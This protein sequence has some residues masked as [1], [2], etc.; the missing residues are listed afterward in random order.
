[1]S[2]MERHGGDYTSTQAPGTFLESFDHSRPQG[3]FPGIRQPISGSTYF[4]SPHLSCPSNLIFFD[5]EIVPTGLAY[6]S[7]LTHSGAN[8][9]TCGW[10]QMNLQPTTNGYPNS[11][12]NRHCP[13][14]SLRTTPGNRRRQKLNCCNQCGK[15]GFTGSELRKH[16]KAHA[17][18][19]K[20]DFQGCPRKVGFSSR[21]DLDRHKWT[22]HKVWSVDGAVFLCPFGTCR[23][24]RKPWPRADNFRAHLGRVHG[25][26]YS[27]SNDLAEYVHRLP[28]SQD[29]EDVTGSVLVYV[30]DQSQYSDGAPLSEINNPSVLHGEESRHQVSLSPETHEALPQT[31]ALMFFDRITPNLAPVQE[32]DGIYPPQTC[33]NTAASDNQT[34]GLLSVSPSNLQSSNPIRQELPGS[35]HGS[36]GSESRGGTLSMPREQVSQDNQLHT[37]ASGSPGS[38][39][40]EPHQS[41]IEVAD[42]DDTVADTIVSGGQ[43]TESSLSSTHEEMVQLLDRIPKHMIQAYLE[44]DGSLGP[45]NGVSERDAFADK[46]QNLPHKCPECDKSFARKC[47]LTKHLMR[48]SRPYGCTFPGCSKGYGS[49]NDWMRHESTMHYQPDKW[50]CDHLKPNSTEACGKVHHHRQDFKIHLAKQHCILDSEKIEEKLK[51]CQKRHNYD[52]SF[53]C[54]FCTETITVNEPQN[55]W[56]QR[57][58]HIEDHFRGRGQPLM[59]IKQWEHEDLSE[60]EASSRPHDIA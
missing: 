1:M 59:N 10:P 46:N 49:K 16:L 22:V 9:S 34:A 24:Q 33:L 52:M 17:L 25:K 13:P 19:F 55:G 21:N 12:W 2:S 26:Q 56:V 53:W 58:R 36:P 7:G 14:A 31:S 18:P 37:E 8:V 40:Q 11:S 28:S 35:G 29:L 23:Q 50:K 38:N 42:A 6:G 48:H 57:C 47:E 54:G 4:Q 39:N 51:F 44:Q 27:A 3:E 43:V 30:E 15:G 5:C 60:K 45:K 41:D 32:D 20:C